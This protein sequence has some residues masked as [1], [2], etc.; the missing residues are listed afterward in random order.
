MLAI[1]P[2]RGGSKGL[3]GKNIKRLHGK[4]MIAYTIEAALKSS[5]ID[6]VIVSTDCEEIAK[7]SLE[8]GAEVPFI[9]PDELASDKSLAIDT[10]LH[11]IDWV[12]AS[13]GKKVEELAVL[14]PTCP[15]RHASDIDAAHALYEKDDVSSVVSYTE[16]HHPLH[17][18]KYLN[19]KQQLI[20]IFSDSLLNRQDERVSYYPNGAIFLFKADLLLN[21]QYYDESSIAYLMPR[22]RSVDVDT[23][24]DFKY[25]EYL[26][27]K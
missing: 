21:K 20:N 5:S 23:L 14:L 7:V 17:W 2:A 15:L 10:Y 26:I 16:E 19:D 8:Y 18:H 3:P 1:I 6:R 11:A 22:E 13:T 12:F 9:R 25:L 24:E 27:G 4:P